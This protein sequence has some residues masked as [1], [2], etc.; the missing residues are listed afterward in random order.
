M[1]TPDTQIADMF[2]SGK[3]GYIQ[4]GST[5]ADVAPKRLSTTEWS[6]D[7]DPNLWDAVPADLG[8]YTYR[9]NGNSDGSFSFS[10]LWKSADTA[11]VIVKGGQYYAKLYPGKGIAPY[12]GVI[13]VGKVSITPK[14]KGELMIAGQ[15]YFVGPY[16]TPA[17]PT[18]I[19]DYIAGT[20]K[21]APTYTGP[22]VTFDQ[23][24][25]KPTS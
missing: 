7:D 17:E 4:V 19:D 5:R 11:P 21:F 8:G 1:T 16:N 18:V 23:A 2:R 25:A 20:G 13:R 14:M 24:I 10:C 9:G 6:I 12:E 22:A 3:H 15:A